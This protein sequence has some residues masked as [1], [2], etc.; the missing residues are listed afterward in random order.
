MVAPA[1]MVAPAVLVAPGAVARLAA[2]PMAFSVWRPRAATAATA[3]TDLQVD[4]VLGMLVLAVPVV[5][6]AFS[7]VLL[8]APVLQEI[9]G[10]QVVMGATGVPVP[11]TAAMA[12][13]AVT[14]HNGPTLSI[15]QTLSNM[16]LLD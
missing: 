16:L 7:P 12:V 5:A 9:R 1:A 15:D 14:G 10:V 13:T 2:G 6:G 8:V 11:N 3:V 4:L